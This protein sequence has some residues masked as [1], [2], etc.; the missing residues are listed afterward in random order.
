MT[1]MKQNKQ[2]QHQPTNLSKEELEQKS[3]KSS[4]EKQQHH[5]RY[6]W[7]TLLST[8]NPSFGWYIGSHFV[9]PIVGLFS[10]FWMN[11][12]N[13]ST[14]Y[15][16][17]VF[18]ETLNRNYLALISSSSQKSKLP[19]RRPLITY[20]NHTSCMDDPLI[21]G[22]LMPF[23]WL[24]NSNRLRWTSAAA[25]I[26]FNSP[27]YTTFFALG[28]T[29]PMIRGD[30]IYQPAMNYASK[31]MRDGEW[32]HFFPEGKVIPR[33][34]NADPKLLNFTLVDGKYDQSQ[35]QQLVN[36]DDKTSLSDNQQQQ[37]SLKWGMARLIIEHVLSEGKDQDD[38]YHQIKP[39]EGFSSIS[40]LPP[41]S[42]KS[43]QSDETLPEVDVLPMYHFG[44][45]DVLPTKKPYIPRIFC[46]VTFLVRP[47][48][49]IRIDRN[50][51]MKLFSQNDDDES[52]STSTLTTKSSSLTTS[53]SSSTT[54]ELSLTEKR[55]RLMKFLEKE[56]NILAAKTKAL[57]FNPKSS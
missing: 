42:S 10:K 36:N 49:P 14:V 19:R 37:Y 57:H 20:C 24:L 31:L 32:L 33:P 39:L 15:N 4:L 12:V 27:I 52:Q 41:S 53:Q 11:I 26:C 1:M 56:L 29:F 45:D 51:L 9:I 23:N 30:G 50:F 7:P 17:N 21:W 46:R 2:Q 28:K 18:N 6:K 35:Q 40:D 38:E 34:E 8:D 47:E 3:P 48:G 44:M 13:K 16:A 54:I 43:N 22:S 25:E 5:Y 55:I